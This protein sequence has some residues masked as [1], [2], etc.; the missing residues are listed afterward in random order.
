MHNSP[1]VHGQ[2]GGTCMPGQSQ[3]AGIMASWPP[4]HSPRRLPARTAHLGRA[5]RLCGTAA[6]LPQVRGP[7]PAAPARACK[8]TAAW[9]PA[10]TRFCGAAPLVRETGSPPCG[11]SHPAWCAALHVI[12]APALPPACTCPCTR[13]TRR[14]ACLSSG[15]CLGSSTTLWI[16]H[17]ASIR[18]AVT[19]PPCTYGQIGGQRWAHLGPPTPPGVPPLCRGLL[20]PV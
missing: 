3:P 20:V 14:H 10:A 16:Q 12:P 13:C 19:G 2:A 9:S 11:T 7:W 6:G 4:S 18:T 1:G 5:A 8:H 15:V 17:Y